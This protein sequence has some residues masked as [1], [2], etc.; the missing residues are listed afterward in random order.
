MNDH[1]TRKLIQ[2]LTALAG[3][4]RRHEIEAGRIR[5]RLHEEMPMGDHG[6]VRVT[7]VGP[8]TVRKHVRKGH[9][10]VTVKI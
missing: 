6:I 8:V 9:K 3:T 7:W 5:T 1:E 10:R 4:M 2:A